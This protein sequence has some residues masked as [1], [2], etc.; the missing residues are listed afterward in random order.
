MQRDTEFRRF[1]TQSTDDLCRKQKVSSTCISSRTLLVMAIVELPSPQC[2][3]CRRWLPLAAPARSNGGGT[4]S[5]WSSGRCC[6]S[7]KVTWSAVSVVLYS[8]VSSFKS[9]SWMTSKAWPAE[10]LVN[11]DFTSKLTITSFLAMESDGGQST[12]RRWQFNNHHQQ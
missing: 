10:T 8:N 1:R 4:H 12:L 6:M 3:P 7:S 5:R 9:L 2:A 11:K